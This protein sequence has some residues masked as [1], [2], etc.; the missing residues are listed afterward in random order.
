MNRHVFTCETAISRTIFT[1]FWGCV[2]SKQAWQNHC[3]GKMKICIYSLY[4]IPFPSWPICKLVASLFP[5]SKNCLKFL[6]V[7]D[8]SV[9][10][11]ETKPT[12]DILLWERGGF[13]GPYKGRWGESSREVPGEYLELLVEACGSFQGVILMRRQHFAGLG[14]SN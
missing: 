8:S 6:L 3:G 4:I 12:E 11:V 10:V 9:V 5:S 7:S 14:V 2:S 1:I 13:W